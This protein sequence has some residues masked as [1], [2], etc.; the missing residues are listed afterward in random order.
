ML[1]YRKWDCIWPYKTKLMKRIFLF[2]AIGVFAMF[3]VSCLT[4]EK[5]QY[6]YEFNGKGGGKLTVKYINIMSNE[7]SAGY[8]RV[9]DF[10]D[11]MNSYIN[12]SKIEEAYPEATNIS[13]RLF[14][15]NGVLCAE[16]IMD[17]ASL[18]A[19]RLYQFDKKSPYMFY[20]SSVDGESY[21]ESSGTY[22]G[23]NM[24]VVMFPSKLKKLVITT[25]VS[26]PSD[27]SYV[28]LLGE[29]IKWKKR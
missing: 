7:D 21:V 15:E 10:D 8:S 28:S 29:Y 12:G 18:N 1:H 6:T 25:S 13:K 14:E 16:V 5:K 9:E 2:L 17:F 3:L 11:L 20:A 27:D 22:G 19:A 26:Q 4:V 24:P 23:E